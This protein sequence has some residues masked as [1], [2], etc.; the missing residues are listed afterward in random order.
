MTELEWMKYKA[1][2]E[3]QWRG[4]GNEN[5]AKE[6]HDIIVE[7]TGL[8]YQKPGELKTPKERF[9]LKV[10]RDLFCKGDQSMFSEADWDFIT[11]GQVEPMYTKQFNAA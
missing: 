5:A 6:L 7:E 10:M 4:E 11:S 2:L 9:H 1:K 8:L 3:R